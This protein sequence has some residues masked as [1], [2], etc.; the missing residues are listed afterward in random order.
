MACELPIPQG[1]KPPQ[2]T[3]DGDEFD[4]V[5]TFKLEGDRLVLVAID[6]VDLPDAKEESEPEPAEGEDEGDFIG[7]MMKGDPAMMKG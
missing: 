5:A 4:S 6:G 1:F 2:D 3:Q 7:A